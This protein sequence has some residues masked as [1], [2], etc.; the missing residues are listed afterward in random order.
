VELGAELERVVTQAVFVGVRISMLMVFAPFFGSLAIPARV[1]AGLTVVLTALLYPVYAPRAF[2]FNEVSWCRV[3]AGE[4][5]VGLI[6]GLTLTFVFEGAELAGQILGFQ[7]GYSLVNV[8]DPQ[9]QVDTPVLSIFHQTVVLLLFLQLG[10]HRWLLRG[11]AKSFEYLPPGVPNA[12]PRATEELLHA[13]AAMVV[14]AVQIAAPALI[15]TLLADI[16]LGLIGK[17][18]PQLP[19]L[20]TG[21]SVKALVGF[22]VLAG[23]LRYWPALME[24]YFSR[25]LQTTEHLLHLAR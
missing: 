25:A 22:L 2:N 21:L 10:V 16:V 5:I 12:T 24:R 3:V 23:A 13:S 18:S 9:T 8:I 20:F 7:L 19:V 14:I 15:A 1:K 11:L 4:V 6:L 17:A